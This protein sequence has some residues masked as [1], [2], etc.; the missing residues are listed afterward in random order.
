ML[1]A[2]ANTQGVQISTPHLPAVAPRSTLAEQWYA[3]CVYPRHEKAVKSYLNRRGVNSF[4]P[5]YR[6]VRRWKDRQKELELVLFPGYVFVNLDVHDRLKVLESPSVVRF[7]TFQGRPAS[8]N[9]NEVQSLAAGLEAGV[10][11]E[12]HPYIR[13]G[14]RVRVVR[15]PLAGMEGMMK[16]R[17]DRYRLV[18]SIDLIMRSVMLEVDEADVEPC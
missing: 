6:S 1:T 8:I 18:L 16:R 2:V 11:A 13:E 14:K 3:V 15:G 12:P 5:L 9:E 17:K 10:K 7:V 4:L